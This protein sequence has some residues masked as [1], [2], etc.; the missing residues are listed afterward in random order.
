M[1]RK[2]GQYFF[3]FA[4]AVQCSCAVSSLCQPIALY[5]DTYTQ[6]E[7][8]KMID[9]A[10]NMAVGLPLGTKL[11]LKLYR[12]KCKRYISTYWETAQSESPSTA[13]NKKRIFRVL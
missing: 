3:E 2:P 1:K 9:L 7:S 11:L 5:I 8:V 12:S 10:K 13:N 6:P 4:S